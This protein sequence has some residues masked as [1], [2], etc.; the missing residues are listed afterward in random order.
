LDNLTQSF[1]ALGGGGVFFLVF[2][3][4]RRPLPERLRKNPVALAVAQAK[5]YAALPLAVLGLV[6]GLEGII[7]HGIF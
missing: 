2:W 5:A 6:I 4:G 1:L 7:R 3:F